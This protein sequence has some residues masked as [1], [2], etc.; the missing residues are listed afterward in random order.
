[1]SKMGLLNGHKV[2]RMSA[3]SFFLSVC[4]VALWAKAVG[5]DVSHHAAEQ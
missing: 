3:A 1:M 2:W 4:G 5:P